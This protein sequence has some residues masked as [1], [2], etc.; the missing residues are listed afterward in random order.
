MVKMIELIKGLYH[1]ICTLPNFIFLGKNKKYLKNV[2]KT[3]EEYDM[4]SAPS[5]DY[6][7][8]RYM[9]I[10]NTIIKDKF[11]TENKLKVLDAGCGQGRIAV[12]LGEKGCKIDAIDFVESALEKAKTYAIKSS[13]DRDSINWIK[14]KLPEILSNLEDD[15]YDIVICLEVLFMMP[16]EESKRCFEALVRLVRK[17]G[18]LVT[19]VRSRFFYL[20]HTLMNKDFVRLKCCAKNNDFGKLGDGLSWSDPDEIINLF[21]KNRLKNTQRRGIGILSGIKGDPTSL[22]CLPLSLS[23]TGIKLLGEIEDQYGKIYP[24]T[25]RYIVFWGEK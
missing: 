2:K 20:A 16:S 13:I 24:D 23:E 15:S 10:I 3:M 1:W 19:S 21:K 17:G 9:R 22:F 7:K 6:F 25:G 8:L 14:G 12:A 5:E 11:N 18:I 4:V